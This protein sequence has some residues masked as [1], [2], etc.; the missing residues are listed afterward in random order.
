LH[1]ARSGA[2]PA[3]LGRV[4]LHLLP[5]LQL[6]DA[7]AEAPATR[8]ALREEAL[9]GR[10]LPG[11]GV[12]PLGET[13]AVVPGVPVSVELRSRALMTSHPDPRERSRVVLAATRRLLGAKV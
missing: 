4:P 6:A 1:L 5:Y 9:H 8:D 11:A 12:L 7:A 3:D 13:L 10:L 2:T